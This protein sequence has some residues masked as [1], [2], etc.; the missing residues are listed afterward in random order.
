MN[1]I[2][3]AVERPVALL[4]LVLIV[5]IFGMVALA[6]IPVQLAPDVDQ[7]T[8]SITTMWAGSAP[9][10]VEREILFR[11]EEALKG[12]ENVRNVTS[13]AEQGRARVTLEFANGTNIDRALLLVGNRLQQISGYPNEVDEPVLSTAGTEDNPIAW[14]SL[15]R[16]AGNERPVAQFGDLVEDVVRERMQRVEGVSEVNVYGGAER[17]IEVLVLPEALARYRLT[18]SDLVDALRAANATVSAGDVEEGKRSYVVR[19]EGELKTVEAVE[20]VVIRSGGSGAGGSGGGAPKFG[21][22]TVGD[23]AEVQFG[24]PEPRATIRQLGQPALSLNVTRETGANVIVV[25][26]GI[27]NAVQELNEGALAEAGLQLLWNYDETTYIEASIELVQSNIYIGGALAALVLFLFLRS[28][29]ATA[30]VAFAIPISLIGAF[31]AMAALGRSINVISLAGL[32][33]AVGMVVDAAIVVQENIYRL[34][35]GG[36]RARKAAAEGAQQVWGAV[37]AGAITTVLVFVPILILELE[38]G[39]LFRDIAVALSVA[40]VLSLVV[41]VTVVPSLSARFLD[42]GKGRDGKPHRH[43]LPVVDEAASLFARGVAGYTRRVVGHRLLA[44]TVV[45]SVSAAAGVAAWTFLPKL[46]YLPEGNRNLVIGRITPPPGYNLKT[47]EQIATRLEDAVRP[48]W[49]DLT[50]SMPNAPDGEAP[51]QMRRFFFVALPTQIIIG[52]TATDESRAGELVP[53]I[54]ALTYQEPGAYGATYQPSIFGRGVSGGRTIEL[55][56]TG[57]TMDAILPVAQQAMQRLSE[58]FPRDAGNQLRPRPGLEFGAP[59]LRILP[60]RVRLAD[61]GVTV[62]QFA[63]AIDAFNDGLRVA[64][65]TIGGKRID[66]TLLGTLGG[67]GSTQDI[68][69]LP[70]VTDSGVILPVSALADIELTAGPVTI[71]H[72]ERLRTI[73][74][75]IRP[76]PDVPLEQA[77]E[78][79]QSE[80]VQPLVDAG[81][82]GGVA[83]SVSGTAD[84]LTETFDAMV[85]NLALAIAIVYLVMAILFESFVYPLVMMLSV[86]LAAAG[87]I[88]GLAAVNTLVVQP[89]DMLTLLGFVILIGTVVNNAILLVHQ[90]LYHLRHERMDPATAILEATRN[91]IRPIFMSTV[92][93]VAGMLPLVVAPGAGSE[94]YRGIGAVVV[95]GLMLSAI[96]TLFVV[97]PMLSV[98]MGLVERKRAART[99]AQALRHP[100]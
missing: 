85:W 6:R 68:A 66:M 42:Y 77:L 17:R 90:S 38:V 30:A 76:T 89:L 41:A 47:V 62:R 36:M 93:S 44:I 95:G 33:F 83:F 1:L 34:H 97:P 56:V 10:E 54:Q 16:L 60:D 73:T 39:Q 12:L 14:F 29:G 81:L 35:E 2:R 24:Y 74:L 72:R 84:K 75:E 13:N 88:A 3:L 61:A 50:V 92:T 55:D 69:N 82:P 27:R 98:V 49:E 15:V 70:V 80:V 48:L 100:S 71:R 20:S 99:L 57:P 87:G 53:T 45:L 28:F 79:I 7:P 51:L 58:I 59:E 86:P 4:S 94:L 26:D 63:D 21:R 25:M 18:V 64:E 91:R 78:M 46:E 9:E 67:A 11:Q 40:I 31:V 52:A 32:A 65:V 37:M 5:L 23:L 43:Y 8:I 96:L 22:V 19:A